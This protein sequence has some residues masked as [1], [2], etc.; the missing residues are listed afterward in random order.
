M[1]IISE[2]LLAVLVDQHYRKALA[3]GSGIDAGVVVARAIVLVDVVAELGQRP[4]AQ[5]LGRNLLLIGARPRIGLYIEFIIIFTNL[6]VV[7]SA[8]LRG[9]VRRQILEVATEQAFDFVEN[10]LGGL[11]YV[12]HLFREF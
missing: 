5:G 4:L 8:D 12:G 7:L 1:S 9:F 11:V 2:A 3:A 6:L 10:A